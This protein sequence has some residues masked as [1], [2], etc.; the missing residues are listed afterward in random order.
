MGKGVWGPGEYEQ[1]MGVKGKAMPNR[2]L[3]SRTHFRKNR[4]DTGGLD[5]DSQPQWQWRWATKA[6]NDVDTVGVSGEG[7]DAI[8]GA[9]NGF[10][11]Q[12]GIPN[13]APESGGLSANIPDGYTLQ[14]MSH[15]HYVISKYEEYGEGVSE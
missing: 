5:Q 4:E 14:V 6:A 10:F 2:V 15:D 1:F 8:N 7:Y 12:Q 13:W 11:S 3:V 9:V